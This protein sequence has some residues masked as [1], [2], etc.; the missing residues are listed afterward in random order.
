MKHSI[1]TV[2]CEI[3][4]AF[5]TLHRAGVHDMKVTLQSA[6]SLHSM[7]M[8]TG[9]SDPS[10]QI[11]Q[12]SDHVS[13]NTL[14]QTN[15]IKQLQF[16]LTRSTTFRITSLK[17]SQ[18]TRHNAV[19]DGQSG[20]DGALG[21]TAATK[22]V[23]WRPS[24]RT[25]RSSTASSRVSKAAICSGFTFKS[26]IITSPW[27]KEKKLFVRKGGEAL[28]GRSRQTKCGQTTAPGAKWGPLHSLI[29]P[30]DTKKNISKSENCHIS[31]FLCVS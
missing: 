25:P 27:A 1:C 15:A 18:S 31:A 24:P 4:A 11:W 19:T 6:Q 12:I 16:I 28:N 22:P 17:T 23:R 3:P 8:Q 10:V 29:W 30:T 20:A 21:R 7:S 26:A 5:W 9:Q 14:I 2:S 13:P